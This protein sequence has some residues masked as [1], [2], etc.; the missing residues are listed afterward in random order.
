MEAF[1]KQCGDG[2]PPNDTSVDRLTLHT[3]S[4]ITLKVASHL[5]FSDDQSFQQSNT[6]G[7]P[8]KCTRN[9]QLDVVSI[10]ITVLG[11]IVLQAL[12]G[13]MR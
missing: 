10:H 8:P 5:L 13:S 6:V 1:V 12:P 7:G 9:I 4:Q 2:S 11:L 3:A